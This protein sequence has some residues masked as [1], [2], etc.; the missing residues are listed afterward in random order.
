MNTK[1]IYLTLLTALVAAGC[2]RRGDEAA[3]PPP[4]P[5]VERVVSGSISVELSINPPVVSLEQDT[6]LTITTTAPSEMEIRLPPSL[7]DRLDGFI[8]AGYFDI[9]ERETNGSTVRER[10]IRLTP[11]AADRWRIAPFI[12][13]TIDNSYSPPLDGWLHTPALRLAIRQPESTANTVTFQPRLLWIAPDAAAMLRIALRYILYGMAGL[14]I[15]FAAYRLRRAVVLWRMS[16][17]ERALRELQALMQRDLI[18]RQQV[19][20]FYLELTMI[21]RRYIERAHAIRAPEQTTEEFL[22]AVAGDAR[23]SAAT[24]AR[25]KDFLEASDLVKFAGSRPAPAAIDNAA[26]TAREY[27]EHDRISGET[28]SAVKGVQP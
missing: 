2:A 5:L 21:V 6:I 22:L 14:L 11:L 12:V 7:Q 24:L 23:F 10:R 4:A 1:T 8:E 26:R 28:R 16:P 25:L 3:A 20:Q 13:N 19:K 27:I 9:P 17:R 15:I 18:G